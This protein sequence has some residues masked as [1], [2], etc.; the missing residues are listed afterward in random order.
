MNE[1]GKQ[2]VL[3]IGGIYVDIIGTEYPH[4]G[5][6]TAEVELDGEQYE[7]L[8]GGSGVNFGRL[9]VQLGLDVTFVGKVGADPMGQLAADLLK[10]A[11]IA[12]ALVTDASVQTNVGINLVNKDGK[13]IIPGLGNANQALGPEDVLH[14]VEPLLPEL[15]YL[16]LGSCLKLKRLL[17]VYETLARDAKSQ[18]V[19]LVVDHG[20]VMPGTSE[21]DIR[22]VK[23]LALLA[24][25]YLPSR[26][27]FLE[28]WGVDSIEAGLRQ[29]ADKSQTVTTIVKDGE[30]GAYVLVDGQVQQVPALPTQII[31]TVGAGDSFNAGVI[32]AH[33]NGKDLLE[34]I[35]FGCAVASLKISNQPIT[36]ESVEQLLAA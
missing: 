18:N 20:R 28:V 24:D 32:D 31:N 7:T 4:D 25:F 9:C 17:P 23:E 6:I 13:T 26:D 11:G 27:E 21:A 10:D 34:S 22:L 29:I 5:S 15:D 8:A 33:A 3:A 2:R 16:Y 1:T 19:K 35:R 12:P 30:Q 14:K 36:H